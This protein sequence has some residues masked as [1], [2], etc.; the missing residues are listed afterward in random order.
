MAATKLYPLF[1]DGL[2][3]ASVTVQAANFTAAYNSIHV[4]TDTLT[5]QLP[6]P[7]AKTQIVIKLLGEHTI[8]LARHDS[9]SIEGVAA[10]YVLQSTNESVTLVSNG[11]DWFI[12]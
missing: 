3:P 10:N 8:T 4:C 12:I 2:F 1:I 7:R 9:E 11:V 6:E 5:I